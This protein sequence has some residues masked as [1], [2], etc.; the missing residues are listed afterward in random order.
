LEL[1]VDMYLR[2]ADDGGD[3]SSLDYWQV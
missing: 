3:G 1:E 2:D